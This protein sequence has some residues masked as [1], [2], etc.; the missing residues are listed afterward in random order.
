MNVLKLTKLGKAGKLLSLGGIAA[1]P[2]G[3]LASIAVGIAVDVAVDV[4]T[5]QLK[6]KM[7]EKR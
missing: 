3:I 7:E 6:K 2:V 1:G 5:K 4:A